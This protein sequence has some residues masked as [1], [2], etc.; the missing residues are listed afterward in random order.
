MMN[1]IKRNAIRKDL[2]SFL[3]PWFFIITLG[4]V[5]TLWEFARG[6]D[7]ELN[8]SLS[9]ILG[10]LFI[11]FALP[12]VFLGAGTLRRS[13]SSTLLIREDHQLIQHGIYKHVRH[14]IY[15]GT[16]LVFLGIPLCL[17]S[18]FGFAIMALVIPLFLNRIRIEEELLT[19]E[20]GAEY[21]RYRK[22]SRKL[23]PYL[24]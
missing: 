3:L 7:P 17:A 23:I 14:P 18:L 9:S 2:L 5:V 20:F 11:I 13:Y 8:L 10:L 12:I 24:F 15:S 1:S 6:G 19:E 22:T 21:E 4:S 16:I